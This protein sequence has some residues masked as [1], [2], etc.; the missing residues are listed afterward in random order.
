MGQTSDET[1][2]SSIN[3]NVTVGL[4]Q[5]GDRGARVSGVN[6]N[7]ELRLVS[8]LNAELTANGLHGTVRSEIP[9]VTVDQEGRSSRYSAHIGNG[10]P[11]IELRGINGNVRL[12]SAGT[13]STTASNDQKS[14]KGEKD[15]TQKTTKVEK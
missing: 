5:L 7:I 1:E 10:G 11:P 12:T 15:S 6:G 8:G 4:K 13:S 14:A 9:T 3:G 2:I